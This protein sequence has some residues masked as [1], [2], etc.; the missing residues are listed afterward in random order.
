V[1]LEQ[2]LFDYLTADPTLSGLIGERLFPVTLPQP[3]AQTKLP[4]VS[5]ER[6][7]A[8]RLYTFDTFEDTDAWPRARVSFTCWSNT[9]R[10]A[11][12][13]GEAI[14][15]ALSGYEGDMAGAYI[16]SSFAELELDG[17]VPSAKLYRRIVDFH[18]AYEDDFA[19]A[20]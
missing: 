13:V 16:G 15:A 12:V 19:S 10:E 20:S 5:Y 3:P 7:S 17:Y 11:I 8:V 6:V 18:I 14:M 4:A 2:A 9:P 1:K